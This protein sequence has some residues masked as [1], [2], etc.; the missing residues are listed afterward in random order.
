MYIK[1]PVLVGHAEQSYEQWF[2]CNAEACVAILEIGQVYETQETALYRLRSVVW[3][4]GYVTVQRIDRNHDEVY[5]WRIESLINSH[6][7]LLEEE[8][9]TREFPL[10]T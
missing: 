9:S 2:V 4:T 6:M 8:K 7:T 10:F 1:K 3:H 5:T